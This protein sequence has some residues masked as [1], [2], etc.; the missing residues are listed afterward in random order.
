NE[1]LDARVS[2]RTAELHEALSREQLLRREAETS[3]RLKD[4]F[5]M[6]VSHELRTPLNALLGWAD[7]LRLGIVPGD[8]QPRAIESIYEN[9]KV[10]QQLIADLLDTG[11]ILTGK[12]RIEASAI[13][14]GQIVRDAVS[15]LAPAADAKGLGLAIAR[16]LVELH[17]GTIDGARNPD[18]QGAVFTVTLP[19]PRAV[20]PSPGD[21]RQ[22][23]TPGRDEM[24]AL[25][26]VR[27]LLVDDNPAAREMM[28]AALEHC[29]ATV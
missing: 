11:R 15:V 27:V 5:L 6:T 13:D 21:D 22:T 29:G 19:A 20:S 10:Q 3:S 25:A 2:S 14:L 26:G 23:V 4:E 8:R 9:A 16:Q 17:G 7:M 28:T 18:G 12:L 1:E 24:P